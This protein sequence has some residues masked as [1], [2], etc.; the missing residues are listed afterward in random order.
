MFISFEN[1]SNTYALTIKEG[2]F[3][4]ASRENSVNRIFIFE[5]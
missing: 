4:V 3:C 1:A 5:K 2:K